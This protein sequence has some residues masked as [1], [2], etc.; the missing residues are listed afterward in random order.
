M[1]SKNY[2]L[3][4]AM[5][6]TGN[7]NTVIL[8]HGTNP[9]AAQAIISTQQFKPGSSGNLGPGVY[10]S[11]DL[12]ICKMFGSHFLSAVVNPG[13]VETVSGFVG[14]TWHS[15]GADTA[16]LP[17]TNSPR[18]LEEWCIRIPSKATITNI[19]KHV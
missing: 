2:W 11:R 14:T 4:E 7:Q 12:T 19:K 13:K 5:H 1:R 6:F 9:T 3:V 10:M 15:K 16:Y 18:N 17:K 8:Y